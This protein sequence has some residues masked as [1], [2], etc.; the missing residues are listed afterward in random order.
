MGLFKKKEESKAGGHREEAFVKILGTGCAKCN[1]LESNVKKAMS[2]LGMV[3]EVEHV[4]DIDRI[5]SY[6]VMITPALVIGNDVVS[7]GKV[8]SVAEAMEILKRYK[9]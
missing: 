7:V 8:L 9:G 6:G 3:H 2:E 4:A 1:S 5:T